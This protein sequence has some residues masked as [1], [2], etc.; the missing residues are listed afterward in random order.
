VA[1]VIPIADLDDERLADYRH[2]TDAAARRRDVF[3]AEGVLVIRQLV[4]SRYPVRS[5]LVTA[6]RLEALAGDVA[7]IDGPIYVV[8]QSL[9]NVVTGFNIHRGALASATRLPLPPIPE[10]MRSA[11]RLAVVE[12]I[13]DHENMGALFR[14]AAAFGVD[15]VLLCPRSCDPLY[16]RAVRVS[17]GQVLHVPFGRLMDW[18]GDLLALRSAG[19]ALLALTPDPD[20]EAVDA[21]DPT[22]H[23]RWAALFGAEGPGLTE[24]ALV[25]ADRRVRI[26]MATG[27]D[28]LNV[29][30][31]AAI[32]FHRLWPGPTPD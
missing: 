19:F 28:S 30:T 3:V 23:R 27:V 12:G 15:A 29:A 13:T 7:G 31:A 32:T 8:D 25:S 14:N 1:A 24:A 26:P 9:M 21:L 18:P 16:R 17:M 11:E 20:A 6:N 2:L 5:V 4:T 22:Q 10:L